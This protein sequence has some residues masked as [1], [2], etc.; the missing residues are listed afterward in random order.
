MSTTAGAWAGRRSSFAGGTTA[1]VG[2]GFAGTGA[3]GVRPT[4]L[5]SG[6]AAGLAR[7][8]AGGAGGAGTGDV[9][10]VFTFGFLGR[11]SLEAMPPI[12]QIPQKT[13]TSTCPD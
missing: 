2:A 7:E 5:G 11:G 12:I 13:P 6:T 1:G 10:V 4:G 8:G 3:A 9:R